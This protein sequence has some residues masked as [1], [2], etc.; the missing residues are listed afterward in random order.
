MSVRRQLFHS[1]DGLTFHIRQL[2][3]CFADIK[4]FYAFLLAN[5]PPKC[6][7]LTKNVPFAVAFF[8]I[9]ALFCHPAAPPKQ[10]VSYPNGCHGGAWLNTCQLPCALRFAIFERK[11]RHKSN[12]NRGKE[13]ERACSKVPCVELFFL[14]PEPSDPCVEN[15]FD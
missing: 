8:H 7:N 10:T 4:R 5:L 12:R 9:F 13:H 1:L 2:I 14:R 3:Y 15:D 11:Q 6:A